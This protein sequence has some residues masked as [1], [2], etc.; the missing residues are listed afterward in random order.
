MGGE[1]P[2]QIPPRID[3]RLHRRIR[4]APG[5]PLAVHHVR[6][7]MRSEQNR[8]HQCRKAR[9]RLHAPQALLGRER[10][11][12]V[13]IAH[14]GEEGP[15]QGMRRLAIAARHRRGRGLALQAHEKGHDLRVELRDEVLKIG[16]QHVAR[17]LVIQGRHHR[18]G[19]EEL[20]EPKRRV[21]DFPAQA[22][23]VGRKRLCQGFQHRIVAER[24]LGESCHQHPAI[25]EHQPQARRLVVLPQGAGR[26]PQP[27]AHAHRCRR[28]KSRRFRDGKR[29]RQ[30]VGREIFH[31]PHD[32]TGG[33]SKAA[34]A[35]THSRKHRSSS[36]PSAP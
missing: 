6:V 24:D 17:V 26:H 22:A 18:R 10:H 5:M 15:R 1:R 2:G 19:V 23:H 20:R 30:S 36:S 13:V 34:P 12:S 9:D 11:Q 29:S 33:G 3:R 16:P 31:A 32:A 4:L 14:R 35:G 21:L 25:G 7:A 27:R 8:R 28:D